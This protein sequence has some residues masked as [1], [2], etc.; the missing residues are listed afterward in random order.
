MHTDT[1]YKP[2]ENKE[3]DWDKQIGKDHV[4]PHI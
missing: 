3:R 1:D 2:G 4:Y